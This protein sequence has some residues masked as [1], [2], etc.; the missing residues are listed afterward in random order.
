MAVHGI[1]RRCKIYRDIRDRSDAIRRAEYK[2]LRNVQIQSLN[3]DGLW[4]G[5]YN[6]AAWGEIRTAGDASVD[7]SEATAVFCLLWVGET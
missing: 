6:R 7:E 4:P 3:E 5:A 2:Q 1:R